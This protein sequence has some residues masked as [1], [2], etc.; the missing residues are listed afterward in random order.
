MVGSFIKT[1]ARDAYGF[2]N[3]ENQRYALAR[4]PPDATADTS[5]R[6]TG[7][8]GFDLGRQNRPWRHAR[9]WSRLM[10]RLASTVFS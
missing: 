3:P 7:P 5:T 8:A 4:P 6:I 10:K 9:A 1:V 2:R